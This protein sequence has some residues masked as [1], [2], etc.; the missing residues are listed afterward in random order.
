MAS[1]IST[2]Q[3]SPHPNPFDD[4]LLLFDL[5]CRRMRK[6]FPKERDSEPC[7]Y[8]ALHNNLYFFSRTTM[9]ISNEFT[10]YALRRKNKIIAAYL[11][12]LICI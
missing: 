2:L 8:N 5:Q 6:P 9:K 7:I 10:I 1:K 3:N 4:F 11:F 12:Y